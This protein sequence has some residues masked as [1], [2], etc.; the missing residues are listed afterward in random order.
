MAAFPFSDCT[1]EL[2]GWVHGKRNVVETNGLL[3]AK[4]LAERIC[5]YYGTTYESHLV[6]PEKVA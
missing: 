6:I 3:T 2:T 5:A 4:Q 1:L